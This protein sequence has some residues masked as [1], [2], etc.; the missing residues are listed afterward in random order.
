MRYRSKKQEALYR[1]RRPLVER[2]LEERPGCEACPA[3]ACLDGK[4]TYIQRQAQDVHELV[5]RS[6]GGSILDEKNL[7]TVCRKCHTR[8]TQNQLEAEGIGLHLPGWAKDKDWM[9]EEAYSVRRSWSMG[10]PTTPDWMNN[11]KT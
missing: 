5:N 7:V 11:D 3:F 10:E 2:L 6:Q 8:I 1:K 4:K 9:Y